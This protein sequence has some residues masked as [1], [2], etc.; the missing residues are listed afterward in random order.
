MTEQAAFTLTTD[1]GDYLTA[2]EA[3]IRLCNII[4]NPRGAEQ[5]WAELG[6]IDPGLQCLALI[7][8]PVLR[9]KLWPT[10]DDK[11]KFYFLVY[12]RPVTDRVALVKKVVYD[13][14]SEL[15]HEPGGMT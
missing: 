11:T 13:T 7:V 6:Q 3:E 5:Y 10:L 1:D 12:D 4:L 9:E 15:Y 14:V 2:A 8:N